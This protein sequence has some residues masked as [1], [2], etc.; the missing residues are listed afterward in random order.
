MCSGVWPL[1]V[2]MFRS[3]VS[4][5]VGEIGASLGGTRMHNT[6]STCFNQLNNRGSSAGWVQIT[7]INARHGTCMNLMNRDNSY[8]VAVPES[9][10]IQASE[11][12]SL[13]RWCCLFYGMSICIFAQCIT[14]SIC[15]HVASQTTFFDCDNNLFSKTLA[16]K[17][18][19]TARC[20]HC[21]VILVSG[22]IRKDIQQLLFKQY[23]ILMEN[24]HVYTRIHT[25]VP[26][27]PGSIA[28][29]K[30]QK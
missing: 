27:K 18:W 15:T 16:K 6:F 5:I 13:W 26:L 11:N 4:W 22:K 17:Q 9:M 19:H 23:N 24:I 28:C 29:R 30:I 21:A 1:W 2:F 10:H 12:N 25:H 8:T 20:D 7:F 3:Q 14:F